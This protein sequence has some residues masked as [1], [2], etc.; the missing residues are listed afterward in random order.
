MKE[1]LEV[2]LRRPAR[3]S[4]GDRYET[5]DSSFITYIPQD[6]SRPNGQ[7]LET[8]TLTFEGGEDA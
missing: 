2:F 8:I 1:Q 7:P 5:A 6:I 3:K 4:G